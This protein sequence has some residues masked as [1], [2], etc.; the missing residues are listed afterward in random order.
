MAVGRATDGDFDNGSGFGPKLEFLAPGVNVWI[1]SSGG[2]YSST[3]GTSFAAP[4]AAGIGALVLEAKPDLTAHELRDL[5]RD[6]CDKVGPLPYHNG[7]N[8]R[9]G[10]G[11]ASAEHAVAEARRLAT[12]F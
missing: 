4:C 2:G 11:R 9:Y 8:I 7:H 5:I 6:T 3:T 10:H 12:G 1:P